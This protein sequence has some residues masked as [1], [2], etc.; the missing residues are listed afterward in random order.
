MIRRISM[1]VRG[2]VLFAA[3]FAALGYAIL[4]SPGAAGTGNLLHVGDTVRIA[5]TS[6]GCA[7]ASRDSNVVIECMAEKRRTGSYG[8]ITSDERV[9]VV[10]FRS[11]AVAETVFQ[12]RQHSSSTITCRR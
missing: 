10:R 2:A 4:T 12:A 3:F 5:G 8:T 6:T 9:V 7:V 11:P 1:N